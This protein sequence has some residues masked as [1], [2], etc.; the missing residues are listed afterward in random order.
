MP[1]HPKTVTLSS[2]KGL[3]NV[4]RPE[5]TPEDYLKEA[6]NVDIDKSGGIQKRKGYER[7]IAG[8]V[9]SMWSDNDRCFAVVDENLVEINTDLSLTQIR[10]S[11]GDINLSFD[12]VGD[13]YYFVS[14]YL[15]GAIS[16]DGSYRPFGIT[17]PAHNGNLIKV[18]GNLPE[19]FYQVALTYEDSEGRESGARVAAM[20]HISG[21]GGIKID[22]I[23]PS[24][25]LTDYRVNIYVSTTNGQILYKYSSVNKNTTSFTIITGTERGV[26]PLNSFNV[27]PAPKGTIVKYAHGRM[28]I[29][30]ENFLWYSDPHSLEWFQ[31]DSSFFT[32][33]DPI[34]AIMPTEGGM[35]V[36]SDGLYYIA[37][38]DPNKA[39]V[40]LKEKVK[41]VEGTECL[42][43]GAYIFI[44]NTP[45]GYKWLVTTD[46]GI[47]IC[48][49]DG[50]TLNMTEKNYTFPVADE[51]TAVFVQESGINRYTTTLKKKGDST[52]MAIGD[53]VTTTVIR[54]GII[55]ED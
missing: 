32:F 40:S 44:E 49:N 34:R 6:L 53:Q 36:A 21:I 1:N 35:W 55:L 17:P 45:I 5:R 31:Y 12:S 51:G 26:V 39:S 54:N 8:Y 15:N 33:R 22:N 46:K 4:L 50:I 11:I 18:L 23:P 14:R 13:D 9:S 2:F 20:I 19:G 7:V 25:E 42:V 38:K 41:V 28:W 43:S 10:P 29:A 27:R 48:F 30:D 24:D 16:K 47:F 3:N 52:N 37:G